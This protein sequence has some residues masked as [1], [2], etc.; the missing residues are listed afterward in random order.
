MRKWIAGNLT[1]AAVGCTLTVL[2]LA[3]QV[4]G[5]QYLYRNYRVLFW[6]AVASATEGLKAQQRL[7]ESCD[8][9]RVPL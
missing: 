3:P 2:W 9:S 8:N 4:T 5:Y 6:H 7:I 1:G